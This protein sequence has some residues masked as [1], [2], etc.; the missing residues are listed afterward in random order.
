V[1]ARPSPFKGLESFED[2]D[3][4]A[5]LFF[6]RERE[7]EILVANL[8]ASRLTVLYG[9]TGV[10]KSSV[11]RAGVA[12][13]L[14]ALPEPPAVVVFEDWQDD[15]AGALRRS[16]A[17][18]TGAEPQER[19]AETLEL[20]A[21]MVGGDVVVILDGLEEVFL[22]HGLD[23]GPDSFFDQF[24]EAVTRPSL[25]A[26]FLLSIREDALARLDRFK[27]RVPN[28]FGNYLRLPHLDRTAARE[29]IL[30]PIDRYNESAGDG[31][32]QIELA[33]V[34]AVLDQVAA[35]K[36][37]VGQ[38]GRGGVDETTASAGIE[39][40]YLQLVMER[41]W[42]AETAAGSDLLRLE[43]LDR[44][45]GAD[46]IVRDHLDRALMALAPEQRDVAAAVFNH[47]VTPSGA[48][49][50]HDASD[51]AGYVGVPTPE[52]EPVLSSL[53]AQRILR[54]VPGVQGSELPR[55]EIYHDILADAVLAWRTR[56]E[57]DRELDGVRADAARRH[58][59]LLLL[60]AGAILLAGA[61]AGVTIFAFSQRSEA[62]A[63]ARKAHSR[64]FEASALT[65]LSVDPELSLLLASEAAKKDRGGQAEDVLR[66]A[67]DA[68]RERGIFHAAGPIVA[69]DLSPNGSQLLV[70]GGTEADLYDA[71]T[72]RRQHKLDNRA[73]LA[74]AAFSPGTAA[75]PSLV[76]ATGGAD[77]RVRV[78]SARQ[79]RLVA[80]LRNG[81]A[82]RSV[83]FDAKR[84]LIVSAGGR[85][86]KL[87]RLHQS[88]PVWMVRL[89]YPVTRA[90]FSPDGRLVAVIGN[91]R[92][93]RL[94]ATRTG[95]LERR[96]DDH[97]FVSSVAFSPRGV[98]LAAGGRDPTVR[99]WNTQTGEPLAALARH[100]GP[101]TDVVFA[102]SG[103]VL[104]TASLD[105]T[106]Q[107]WNVGTGQVRGI[108]SAH[109][110]GVTSVAFSPDSSYLLTTSSDRTALIWKNTLETQPVAHLVGHTD[111]VVTGTF[112]PNGN[113]V[114]TGSDDGTARIWDAM[115]P[116]LEILRRFP[117]P[118]VGAWFVADGRIAVAGPGA[119]L[120]LLRRSDGAVVKSFR[121][122][123]P[124]TAGGVSGDGNVIAVALGR[125]VGLV[126]E[127]RKTGVAI[128]QPVEV[129]SVALN[130]D[131]SEV[132]TGGSDGNARVWRPDG[133][134]I[135]T[136]KGG[137]RALTGVAFSPDG[138]LAAGS[139]KDGTATIWN[140]TSGK[141]VRVLKGH[142]GV[143]TSVAF[144]PDDRS[145]VT[146]S[147][148]WDG[149]IWSLQNPGEVQVLR[150][151]FGTVADAQFS[152]DG[153]WVVTAGPFTAQLWQPGIR[154]EL[155]TFGIPGPSQLLVSA[156]FGPTSRVILV[157]SKDGT[158]RTYRCTLC[159]GR[160][161]LLRTARAR[162]AHT[163]RTLSPSERKQYGG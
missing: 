128:V 72:R 30:G 52:V 28:V 92:Y 81:A 59:R 70:A 57:S 109:T 161:E 1:N 62:D 151:H 15:P 7:R 50:A 35:G 36:V 34:G 102:P 6:G 55:Y 156:V 73:Q 147:K 118:L 67:V 119:G 17:E 10:G 104:A 82:V 98:L 25:R 114:V 9:D 19:L 101:I 113:Q 45:G 46:Q 131:G 33:L 14:R 117:G 38:A 8:L 126:V 39:A 134:L 2:S 136:L 41:L 78:W 3:H 12:C 162:L 24:S 51:L 85:A 153:R 123:E 29:A 31:R 69:A 84:Q 159:G 4:D 155:F 66:R 158:V 149:R 145:V 132:V 91:D 74:V 58:R 75:W 146:A 23:A 68:S 65:Q 142:K 133:R 83:D 148:D 100:T 99:V 96:L 112:S 120:H 88:V 26:S 54:S 22:Y 135:R 141:R 150:W 48:K 5:R 154:Q 103:L 20:G 32:V 61:M 63:Q 137:G 53:A 122:G 95:K 18:A 44:L 90:V 21:A 157:A 138:R 163:A 16:V 97:D 49:I 105:G 127:G 111:S 86:V 115:Q 80:V 124:V 79:G 121:F 42:E 89:G 13:D 64:A 76:V 47:L 152:P 37:E 139:S 110:N 107:T 106:A 27:S 130:T 140:L 125:R 71:R 40:P 43:T 60:A 144:S 93:V 11:L 143:V 77:G 56:H 129:T 108:F 94:Y 116:R 87:W 160:E